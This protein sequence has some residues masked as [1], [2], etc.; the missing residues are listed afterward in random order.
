LPTTVAPVTHHRRK[1]HI[2]EN[3]HS[4]EQLHPNKPDAK[5]KFAQLNASHEALTSDWETR[6]EWDDFAKKHKFRYP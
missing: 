4:D 3:S 1:H 2:D 5:D 6:E